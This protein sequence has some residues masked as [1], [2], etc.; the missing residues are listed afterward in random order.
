MLI[1]GCWNL[2]GF[3][4]RTWNLLLLHFIVGGMRVLWDTEVYY[5]NK[6]TPNRIEDDFDHHGLSLVLLFFICFNFQTNSLAHPLLAPS[7]KPLL[8]FCCG[9]STITIL[10]PFSNSSSLDKQTQISHDESS[11]IAL[12]F[13]R[14]MWKCS[15]PLNPWKKERS[16]VRWDLNNS[17]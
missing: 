10:L 13:R 8:T 6:Y 11:G 12:W 9:T 15:R 7:T 16:G 5:I 1:F 14:W 3:A 4:H 17:V 2:F